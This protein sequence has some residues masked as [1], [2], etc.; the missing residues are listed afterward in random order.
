VIG[1]WPYCDDINFL[2][3][4]FQL[5]TTTGN[6]PGTVTTTLIL[7]TNTDETETTILIWEDKI[8][9]EK[10]LVGWSCRKEQPAGIKRKGKDKN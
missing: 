6:I 10:N 8:R 5:S 9:Y 7:F 4:Y 2:E 3:Y 1:K